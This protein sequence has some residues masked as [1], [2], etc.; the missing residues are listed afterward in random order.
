MSSICLIKIF[1]KINRLSH[2]KCGLQLNSVIIISLILGSLPKLVFQQICSLFIPPIWC[3]GQ[4][5]FLLPS[6]SR[7]ASL[8]CMLSIWN[9]PVFDLVALIAQVSAMLSVRCCW[10]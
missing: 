7:E 1:N 6:G 4:G 9:Q 3:L 5:S 10:L 2:L 8:V